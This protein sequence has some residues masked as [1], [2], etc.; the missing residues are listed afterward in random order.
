MIPVK[1][2]LIVTINKVKNDVSFL[3]NDLKKSLT[4]NEL[5]EYSFFLKNDL[6]F[7][8]Y[9]FYSN[10]SFSFQYETLLVSSINSLISSNIGFKSFDY[11]NIIGKWNNLTEDKRNVFISSTIENIKSKNQLECLVYLKEINQGKFFEKTSNFI[12][13]IAKKLIETDNITLENEKIKLEE[14]FSLI[15]SS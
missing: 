7:L 13:S 1:T 14:L 10:Y 2:K 3:F 15:I 6:C 12:I 5:I 4:E 8:L 9:H 11:I